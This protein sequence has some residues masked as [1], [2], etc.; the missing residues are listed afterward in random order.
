MIKK[1]RSRVDK[2]Y[3][4]RNLLI[5]IITICIF[6]SDRSSILEAM[7]Y[8]SVPFYKKITEE[9]NSLLISMSNSTED[10]VLTFLVENNQID[11]NT[12]DIV[13]VDEIIYQHEAENRLPEKNVMKK[14]LTID[15]IDTMRDL[16]FLK[17]NFY[18]VDSRTGISKENFDV[19][20]FLNKDMKINSNKNEPKILIFHTHAGEMYSNS[21]DINEGVV[22]VGEKLSKILEESYGIKVMHITDRYDT[23]NG[24]THLLGA[25]E[26][27]EENIVKILKENPSIEVSIDIHRDGVGEDVKLETDI[28]GKETAKIM[29]VNGLSKLVD[30]GEL[31]Q[32]PYLANENLD[33]NLAFSFQMQLMAN[34]MYPGFTRKVYL[35]AYRYSLH[36]LPKSLLIEVGAQTNTK[37]EAYNAVE[38]LAEILASVILS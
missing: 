26:R 34:K 5:F 24:Q 23:L 17:D 21:E 20:K 35:N 11:Y 38:P 3:Y 37:E 2:L 28:N 4:M 33:D 13:G 12:S 27:M 22:G 15:N 1:S 8:E 18:T 7:V 30:D 32:I 6:F 16:A 10:T 36:M 19:D 9:E 14:D 29:F 31:Q 25:Y